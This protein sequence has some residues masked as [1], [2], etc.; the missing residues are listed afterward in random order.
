MQILNIEAF[1]AHAGMNRLMQSILVALMGVPRTRG[2]E[3][4]SSCPGSP[5][6]SRSPHTRG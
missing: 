4:V 6:D 3:P 2:D 5:V 1:P